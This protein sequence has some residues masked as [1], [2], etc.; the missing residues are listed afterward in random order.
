[1]PWWD[2]LLNDDDTNPLSSIKVILLFCLTCAVTANITFAS[3]AAADS[4]AVVVTFYQHRAYVISLIILAEEF[5]EGRNKD[6]LDTLTHTGS[7]H[8]FMI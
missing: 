7:S 5:N 2:H 3:L 4:E 1:M 6:P 8:I